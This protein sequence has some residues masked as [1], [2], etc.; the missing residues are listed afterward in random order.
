MEAVRSRKE[1]I[2]ILFFWLIFGGFVIMSLVNLALK[3][4]ETTQEVA[5]G[6]EQT[7]P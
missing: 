2:V 1:T 6:P 5:A 7:R 3:S 4:G